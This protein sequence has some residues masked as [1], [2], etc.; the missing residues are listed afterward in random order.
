[1]KTAFLTF[2]TMMPLAVAPVLIAAPLPPNIKTHA[3][4]FEKNWQASKASADAQLAPV[5]DRYVAALTAAQK[6]AEAAA[7]TTDL[8]AITTELEGVRAGTAPAEAPPDLPRSLAGERRAYITTAATLNRT[9]TQRQ[10]DL[11]SKYL[12]T[13]AA[14]ESNPATTK[15]AALSEAVASEKQRVLG[16]LEA[17]GGGAKHRN[18]IV[19]GD[20]SEGQNGASPPGWKKETEVNVTDAMIVSEGP[21]KF[22]R[23]RRLAA[24]RRAN[25]DPEKEIP[26]PANAKAAEFSVRMR[27]KGLVRGKDWG[28]LPSL[29][30]SGRD[31][32]GE[33]V[34]KEAIALKEDGAW[35]RLSGRVLLPD[36]AKTLKVAVGPNGAAG[37]L[38]VDDIEV[39]FR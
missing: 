6:T 39:E 15:D 20:F 23:F 11:A 35:R 28:V 22:L 19:N 2:I 27:V 3:E 4:Q 8:A 5:R 1:M 37:I 38:D 36:T 30:V 16:L 26:V 17:S 10:R 29:N 21:N 9:L 18:V 32:R 14:L 12:Q 7:R 31:A 33:E 24:L 13:L 25:L 34:S